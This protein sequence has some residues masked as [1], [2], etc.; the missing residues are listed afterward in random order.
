MY[1]Y[2]YI[3]INIYYNNLCIGYHVLTYI[4]SMQVYLSLRNNSHNPN[5]TLT[6]PPPPYV[7]DLRY[8]NFSN[9]RTLPYIGK[10][11]SVGQHF[12]PYLNNK[13]LRNQVITWWTRWSGGQ[14]RTILA[15]FVDRYYSIIYV[16]IDTYIDTL[17]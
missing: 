11:R 5:P 1:I 12:I 17:L 10:N 6:P 16:Y 13:Q 7:I 8:S 2:I 15:G 4:V 9:I 14:C 3:Y